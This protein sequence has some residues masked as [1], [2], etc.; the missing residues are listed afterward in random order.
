MAHFLL[1]LRSSRSPRNGL[2]LARKHRELQPPAPGGMPF[3]PRAHHR[4]E[5]GDRKWPRK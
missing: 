4:A 3:S 2:G 5:K 1:N